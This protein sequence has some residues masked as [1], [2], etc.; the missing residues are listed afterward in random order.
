[1][2]ACHWTVIAC[3]SWSRSRT[4]KTYHDI[5]VLESGVIGPAADAGGQVILLY[6]S[7]VLP[8]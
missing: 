5:H 3:V 8:I 4:V 7:A 1:M 6:S 2:R